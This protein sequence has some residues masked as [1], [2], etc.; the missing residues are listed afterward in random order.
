MRG[1]GA[2]CGVARTSS[3]LSSFAALA[4][5]GALLAP[6]TSDGACNESISGV[7]HSF[8]HGDP[9]A[10]A[11]RRVHVEEWNHGAEGTAGGES[12]ARA[13]VAAWVGIGRGRGLHASAAQ[14][15][16]QKRA[17]AQTSTKFI[18]GFPSASMI[19]KSQGAHSAQGAAGGEVSGHL[20]LW[21]RMRLA[22]SL[23]GRD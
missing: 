13:H 6:C 1:D 11:G 5:A 16:G 10:R 12:A 20:T 3:S 18:R 21:E 4:A 9:L 8:S 23:R 17:A 2:V 22:G 7:R 15:S 14:R 19:C